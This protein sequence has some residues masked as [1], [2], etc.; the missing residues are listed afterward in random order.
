LGQDFTDYFL[1]QWMNGR[2]SGM[3]REHQQIYE[4]TFRALGS[5]FKAQRLSGLALFQVRSICL[6]RR[7]VLVQ[8][9]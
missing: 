2:H 5:F 1:N 7:I 9:L 4:V 8:V 3:P 6:E